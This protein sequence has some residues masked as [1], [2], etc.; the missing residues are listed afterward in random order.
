MSQLGAWRELVNRQ[1]RQTFR[2]PTNA[3]HN[4]FPGHM[5]KGLR[6]HTYFLSVLV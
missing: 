5:H 6:S 1:F 3:E 4:W 2:F